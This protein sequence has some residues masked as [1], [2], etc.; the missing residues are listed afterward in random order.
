LRGSPDSGALASKTLP[1]VGERVKLRLVSLLA[2]LAENDV[3]V[4]VRVKRRIEID[5][6]DARVGKFLPIGKPCQIVAK[7]QTIQLGK[8]S[9]DLTPSSPDFLA[10]TVAA[11]PR[12][13]LVP[14]APFSTSLGVT[15]VNG[16]VTTLRP[17][18]VP[19]IFRGARSARKS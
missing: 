19:L 18:A 5:K 2:R 4:A 6:I 15:R 16:D 10:A 13:S 11:Q 1:R 3:V 14:L 7:I 8:T 12:M 9:R 17:A